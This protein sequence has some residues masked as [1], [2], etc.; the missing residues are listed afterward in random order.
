MT[1]EELQAI[2]SSNLPCEYIDLTGD[3]VH[4]YVT[5]VSPV[6]EGQRLIQRHK[7]VYATLGNRLQTEEVHALSIKAYTPAEWVANQAQ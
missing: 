4:W 3:G 1:S 5:V 2:I 7:Q 6:F